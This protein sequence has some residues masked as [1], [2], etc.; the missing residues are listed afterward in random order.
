[1][2]KYFKTNIFDDIFENELKQDKIV[3]LY[4]DIMSDVGNNERDHSKKVYLF[5]LIRINSV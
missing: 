5:R 2:N 4:S 3:N 1:M